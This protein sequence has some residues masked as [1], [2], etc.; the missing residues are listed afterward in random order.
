MTAT[1]G[2]SQIA[3]R[4]LSERLQVQGNGAVPSLSAETATT[5]IDNLNHGQ[6]QTNA[7]QKLLKGHSKTFFEAMEFFLKENRRA[8][9]V[10]LHGLTY[11][12]LV[13]TALK[14]QRAAAARGSRKPAV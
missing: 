11:T 5:W 1:S 9:D 2:L 13:S 8:V 4:A 7:I 3:T 6:L 12:T 10:L 14:L